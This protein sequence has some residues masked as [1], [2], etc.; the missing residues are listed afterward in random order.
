MVCAGT[1]GEES[2]AIVR[3]AM[4]I[5]GEPH[6]LCPTTPRPLR[7]TAPRR[8]CS[9]ACSA[10]PCSPAR[11]RAPVERIDGVLP[12]QIAL[13]GD[14]VVPD[15]ERATHS[16][17][18]FGP[19]LPAG[20]GT[21]GAELESHRTAA[22]APVRQRSAEHAS[23]HAPQE[24]QERLHEMGGQHVL[25]V[26]EPPFESEM[27]SDA[28]QLPGGPLGRFRRSQQRRTGVPAIVALCDERP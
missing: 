19:E 24:R 3:K 13:D 28:G 1:I 14:G 17:V 22:D 10:S 25:D 26:D 11:G 21:V 23:R 15:Q 20:S 5:A 7:R 18:E 9:S 6:P 27:L 2:R 4:P 12:I 16:R 8:A